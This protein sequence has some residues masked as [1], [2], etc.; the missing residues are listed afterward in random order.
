MNPDR[1]PLRVAARSTNLRLAAALLTLGLLVPAVAAEAASV[2]WSGYRIKPAPTADGGFMGARKTDGK[3]TYR[4]DAEARRRTA[5]YRPVQRVAGDR[6]SARAA[7]ILSRYGAVRIADQSAAVD[8]A[9]YALVSDRPLDGA[10]ARARLRA[11]GHAAAIRTLARYMLAGSKKYAGP[12][13]LTVDTTPAEVGGKVKVTALVTSHAGVPVANLPVVLRVPGIA[14]VRET[15]AEGRVAATFPAIEVGLRKLEVVVRKVPEW[16]LLVRK[17]KRAGA[18]R[19]A[20]AG[21]KTRLVAHDVVAVRATPV[22]AVPVAAVPQEIG[23]PFAATFTITGSEGI[24]PRI[25]TASLYGPFP[26]G[27]P[28][29]CTGTPLRTLTAVVNGDGTYR[30]PATTVPSAAVYLW[31]IQ[32]GA[33]QLNAPTEA[34]GGL[35]RVRIKPTIKLDAA[36]GSKLTFTVSGLPAGYDDNAELTLHGPYKAKENATCYQPKKVGEVTVRVNHSGTFISPRIKT[37][38]P[39]FYTWRVRLPAGYLVIGQRTACGGPGSFV[40]VT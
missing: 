36:P 10:R 20:V 16:R 11:T 15:N 27:A 35:V 23:K 1:R 28:V 39:G 3:V 31:K 18:S 7:W 30:S 6:R 5:G 14:E 9:T 24:E 17:P 22:V 29:S 34:C 12:Y 26:Q 37:P 8:V 33:N 21:R 13:T 2:P 38:E 4:L 32:V 40:K 25:A 19:I